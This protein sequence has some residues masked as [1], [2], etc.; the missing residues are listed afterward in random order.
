M[1][2]NSK[3][4]SLQAEYSKVNL[5][6]TQEIKSQSIIS[7]NMDPTILSASIKDAQEL[8]LQEIIGTKLLRKIQYLVYN[9]LEQNDLDKIFD[10]SQE[11]YFTLLENYIKPYLRSKA[12]VILVMNASYKFRN[13]G[14]SRNSDTNVSFTAMDELK[15]LEKQYSTNADHYAEILSRYLCSNKSTYPELL[16]ETLPYEKS[17]KLGKHY[18]NTSGLYLGDIKDNHCTCC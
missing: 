14:V 9:E 10:E 5:L 16:A 6:S 11:T 15:Y 3:K 2:N 4:V 17:P 18:S 8:Y 13:I 1:N 7:L 12:L